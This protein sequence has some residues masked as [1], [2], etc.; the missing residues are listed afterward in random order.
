MKYQALWRSKPLMYT[1]VSIYQLSADDI[2]ATIL[3]RVEPLEDDEF[4]GTAHA[5]YGPI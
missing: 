2:G 4:S 3:V 1:L 5:S